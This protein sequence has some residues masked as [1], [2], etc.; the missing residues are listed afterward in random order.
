[1][2]RTFPLV[3]RVQGRGRANRG[4]LILSKC[5]T[6]KIK[7][8]RR[9]WLLEC[10]LPFFRSPFCHPDPALFYD[11]TNFHLQ[12]RARSCDNLPRKDI[13][14][15]VVTAPRSSISRNRK[16]N[17]IIRTQRALIA[18]RVRDSPASSPDRLLP[19]LLLRRPSDR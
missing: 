11:S 7:C 5:Q 16:I 3:G 2:L 4:N 15:L 14:A 10:R 1:M 12:I 18:V 19:I 8:R 13:N 9:E 17:F 6:S